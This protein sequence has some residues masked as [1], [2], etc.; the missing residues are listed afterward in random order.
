MGFIYPASTASNRLSAQN[1]P[2]LLGLLLLLDLAQTIVSVH[3]NDWGGQLFV[4]DT[5][6][7]LTVEGISGCLL[8]S[9]F[10]DLF[11]VLVE[12]YEPEV[13]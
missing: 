1:N 9:V 3:F 8:K 6:A 13:E 5:I 4:V 7:Q 2:Q 10:V 12:P 11:A